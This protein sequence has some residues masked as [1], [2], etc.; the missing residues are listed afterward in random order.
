[1][2]HPIVDA[3]AS[4]LKDVVPAATIEV[5]GSWSSS[6]RLVYQDRS[7]LG[8]GE[9][10]YAEAID[11]RWRGSISCANPVVALAFLI[12]PSELWWIKS[13]PGQRV[14]PI[15]ISLASWRRDTPAEATFTG[16]VGGEHLPGVPVPFNGDVDG[17]P[18]GPQRSSTG[19]ALI[20]AQPQGATFA[21]VT[22]LGEAVKVG[23]K[24]LWH[25]RSE[26]AAQIPESAR[27]LLTRGRAGSV[28]WK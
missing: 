6:A 1:V 7:Q 27:T 28:K 13:P 16:S 19:E 15:E 5:A 2:S 26:L 14:L 3:I 9:G 12:T 10:P 24:R 23:R 21:I 8:S 17:V 18:L 22:L 11:Y 25:L 20:V 4:A